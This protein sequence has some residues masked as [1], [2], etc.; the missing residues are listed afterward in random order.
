[1]ETEI[2]KIDPR[3]IKLLERNARFMDNKEYQNLVHNLKRDGKLTSVPF[4]Y[5]NDNNEIEVLSGN[6]RVLA[7]I[8]AGFKEIEIMLCKDKLTKQQ[9][10]AIQ[11]SHNSI[12]GQDDQ[13]I[14]KELYEELE[15]IELKKY[16]GLTDEF[17]DFCKSVQANFKI[18]NL[19]YQ[20][21]NLLFLP[22]EIKE[23]KNVFEEI[24]DL[25]QNDCL[26]ANIKDYDNYIQ[27]STLVSKCL[28][29]KNASTTFL[30]MVRL[31]KCNIDT[32]KSIAMEDEKVDYVPLTVLIG[33]SD[34]SKEDAKVLDTA[35]EMM[36]NNGEVKKK[37]KEKALLNLANYY[38]N[39]K[40]QNLENK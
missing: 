27:T 15:S 2:I 30:E 33:S 37:N 13:V 34:I 21:L 14:L 20:A 35:I 12:S 1:M 7:S 40:H 16:S 9:A 11:L 36:I 5:Y 32:L 18:P 22:E 19:T 6:H 10:I 23:I 38:L 29:I 17:N 28:N 39:N 4:C 25:L 24:S 3:R 26:I 31:A 8:D